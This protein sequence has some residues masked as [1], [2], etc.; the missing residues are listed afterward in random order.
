MPGVRHTSPPSGAAPPAL[1]IRAR[2]MMLAALAIAPLLIDRIRLLEAERAE[3]LAAAAQDALEIARRIIASQQDGL[4]TARAMLQVTAR[5]YVALGARPDGCG[6]ALAALLAGVRWVRTVS[7]ARTDGRIVCL[8][9]PHAAGLN[10]SD[11][12]YFQEVRRTGESALS[13]YLIRRLP[14]APTLMAALPVPA[15]GAFAGGVLIAGL[16]PQ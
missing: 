10:V 11:Q 12:S 6:G 2:L 8:T 7:V 3:R 15:E 9:A 14:R 13:D 5:S 16:D 4:A 1:S